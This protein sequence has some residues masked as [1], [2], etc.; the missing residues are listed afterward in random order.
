[1]SEFLHE[2]TTR[3]KNR[4]VSVKLEAEPSGDLSWFT[5]THRSVCFGSCHPDVHWKLLLW[6]TVLAIIFLAVLLELKASGKH[7]TLSTCSLLLPQ[8][9]NLANLWYALPFN[10]WR[11]AVPH[12]AALEK[13]DC[14]IHAL[15]VSGTSK[16]KTIAEVWR[17][18]ISFQIN[19]IA[20]KLFW[21]YH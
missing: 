10:W 9:H 8:S 15:W 7:P 18:W 20:C 19:A 2:S 21:N 17:E 14:Y 4:R 12:A 11:N 13:S 5:C 16:D 3:G 6:M 1:M